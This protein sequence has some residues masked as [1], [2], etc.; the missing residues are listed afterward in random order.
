MKLYRVNWTAKRFGESYVSANSEKEAKELA[1]IGK[2]RDF[3]ANDDLGD[4]FI[5]SVEDFGEDD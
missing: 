3:E 5:E 2:D 4:W 1:N